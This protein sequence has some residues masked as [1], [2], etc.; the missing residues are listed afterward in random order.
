MTLEEVN[1][2]YKNTPLMFSNYWKYRFTFRGIAEDG[3]NLVCSFGEC[4][5]D[6]YRYEVSAKGKIPFLY[7]GEWHSVKVLS[8]TGETLFDWRD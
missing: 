1:E 7:V 5:D 3:N 2:R 8:P 4:N 6:I